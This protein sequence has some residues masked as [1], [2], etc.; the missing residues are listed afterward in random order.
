M[1]ILL[2]SDIHVPTR[3]PVLPNE[4][5]RLAEQFDLVIAVGDFVDLQTVLALKASSKQ[6]YAVHG[7]MDD[8]QVKEHL[9]SKLLVQFESVRV[10]IC[11]GWG[12]PQQIRERI[13]STF[14]DKPG[15][16]FYG[17]THKTDDSFLGSVRFINPG[18][19]CDDRSFALVEICNSQL[20]IEFK[21]L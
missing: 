18:S 16:L 20:K 10:G 13:L 19:F 3:L 5:L 15:V 7:N 12:S 14:D 4:L 9:P 17:H 21:R 6:L 11:H 8:V 2:I 1:N